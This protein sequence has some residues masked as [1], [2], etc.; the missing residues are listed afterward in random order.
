MRRTYVQTLS[1]G[2][3]HPA[4]GDSP[5]SKDQRMRTVLIDDGELKVTVKRRGGNGLPHQGNMRAC[6][7]GTLT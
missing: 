7:I 3:V 6:T 1:G 2:A 5:A 4:T